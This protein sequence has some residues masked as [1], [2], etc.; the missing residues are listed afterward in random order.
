MA[1]TTETGYT[2]TR[3]DMRADLGL[4]LSEAR[5]LEENGIDLEEYH[6]YIFGDAFLVST[7]EKIRNFIGRKIYNILTEIH[8]ET[9]API[10]EI[11]FDWKMFGK[12][13]AIHLDEL[14]EFEKIMYAIGKCV[15]QSENGQEIQF[16]IP[17]TLNSEKKKFADNFIQS[18][19]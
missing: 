6:A 15:E 2:I 14:N 7:E 17:R 13:S 19:R 3:A 8:E 11:F 1:I 18:L 9:P 4:N 10:F 16:T 12:K 5:K